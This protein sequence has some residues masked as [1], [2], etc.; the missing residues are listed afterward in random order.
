MERRR[1]VMIDTR[2]GQPLDPSWRPM[3]S[4]EELGPAN[5]LMQKNS[6]AYQWQWI[7]AVRCLDGV[8]QLA[9]RA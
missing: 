1:A 2:T 8:A 7:P 6:L 9:T 5:A 4:L 3:L